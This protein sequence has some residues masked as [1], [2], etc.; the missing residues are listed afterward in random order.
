[1][2]IGICGSRGI[3]GAAM[4]Y[5][6]KKLGHEILE[7]DIVIEGSSIQNLLPAPL[8]FICVPTPAR[9]DGSCNTD[10]VEECVKSLLSLGYRG[11]IV[12]KS[13]TQPG[14]T[15]SLIDK[16]DNPYASISHSAEWLRERMSFYDFTEG[17][18]LLVVGT[19]SDVAFDLIVKAH[20]DYPKTIVKMTPTESELAKYFHNVFNAMRVVYANGFYEICKKLGA[21]YRVIKNAVVKQPTHVDCYLDVNDSFRGYAGYCLPKD[22]KALMKLVEELGLDCKIFDVIVKDNYLYKSTVFPGMRM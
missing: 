12:I 8:V 2:K 3:L 15:Q 11:H 13:T 16:S 6:F 4:T 18:H 7:H 17:H 10:I 19:N 21:N 22:S 5:G 9:V 14:F 1:M 20:G